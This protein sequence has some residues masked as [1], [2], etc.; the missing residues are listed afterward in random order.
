MNRLNFF[1]KIYGVLHNVDYFPFWLLTPFRKFIRF[2]ANVYLPKY[3]FS[4][5]QNIE[6]E[7]TN[8]I[9]SLTSF[10]ARINEVWQVIECIKRQSYRPEKIILWLSKKQ[11][12][13]IND[14]PLSLRNIESDLFTIRFV[15]D[16]IRSHKK[17][18]YVAKEYP[19]SLIL[20]IDDDIYYPTDM[21][22]RLYISY[23]NNPN[24][25]VCQYGY[26]MKFDDGGNILPYKEWKFVDKNSSDPHLFFGS[27]GGT[28]FN[29]S[30]LY[31][32]LL[33][34][35][36]ALKLCPKADDIWLNAMT[37]LANVSIIMLKP[38]LI[39]PIK[40]KGRK[41][42]LAQENIGGGENDRQL[43]LLSNYYIEI[44]GKNPFKKYS[45]I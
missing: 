36:T 17:Y 39:L 21:I 43:K 38:R 32:D 14:V 2:L 27:G 3:L 31:K 6:I 7:K 5:N 41:V 11:F 45:K 13:S 23:I 37:K 28:L 24:S 16:D 1:V 20:L 33:N 29:P 19:N 15:D 10:P 34:I 30:H 42:T 26:F 25:V 18:Y 35:D 22:E 4:R 12:E 40:S 44:L 8:I 9:V